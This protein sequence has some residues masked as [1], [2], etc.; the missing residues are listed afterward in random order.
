M[1]IR[2]SLDEVPEIPLSSWIQAR[3]RLVQQHHRGAADQ[4]H[5]DRQLALHAPRQATRRLVSV[6]GQADDGERLLRG[7]ARVSF[8]VDAPQPREETEMV[9]TAQVVPEDVLLVDDLCGTQIYGAFVLNR[10]VDLYAIDAT[11]ARWRGD[12]SS[13][14]LD[15]ARTAASSPRNDLVLNCR[16]HGTTG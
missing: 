13:S 11:P 12:A 16:V 2:D 15:R 14:P 6:F 5:R 3:R 4:R 8:D 10:R 7:V 1:C 9:S